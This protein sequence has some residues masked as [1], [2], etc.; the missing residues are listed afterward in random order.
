[1]HSVYIN[2]HKCESNVADYYNL[3]HNIKSMP[4]QA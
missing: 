4:N 1:M 3:Q 2:L